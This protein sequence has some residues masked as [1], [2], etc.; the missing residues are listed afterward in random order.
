MWTPTRLLLNGA[1][2]AIVGGVPAG[3]STLENAILGLLKAP[4][5]VSLDLTFGDVSASEANFSGYDRQAIPSWSGPYTGQGG[6]SLV[7]N[8]AFLFEQDDTITFNTIYGG[9]LLGSDSAT[10]L[11]VELFDAAIPMGSVSVGFVYTPIF[12]MGNNAAGYGKSI[13][14]N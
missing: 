10:L 1:M 12:G 5:S 11:A 13:V 3:G 9:F 8:G 14:S 2:T 4:V 7:S 6:Y